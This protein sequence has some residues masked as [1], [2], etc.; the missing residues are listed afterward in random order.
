MRALEEK[1]PASGAAK[2]SRVRN[3]RLMRPLKRTLRSRQVR[4]FSELISS[5]TPSMLKQK[6]PRVHDRPHKIGDGLR[7]IR[8]AFQK[9]ARILPVLLRR[10]STERGKIQFIDQPI[11]I[12]LCIFSG[13]G[14]DHPADQIA[15][16]QLER[17]QKRRGA[18][19]IAGTSRLALGLAE[20]D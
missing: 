4:T 14:A 17:L 8:P 15:V 16:E 20:S 2:Q 10:Q 6:L 3:P 19:A 9:L 12:Q 13:T 11:V 7:S 18:G 1:R 5:T